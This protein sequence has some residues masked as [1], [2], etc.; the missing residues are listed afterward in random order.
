MQRRNRNNS[1]CLFL[2]K[3]TYQYF[4][5]KVDETWEILVKISNEFKNSNDTSSQAKN[6]YLKY[7][8]KY[9]EMKNNLKGIKERIHEIEKEE[10]NNNQIPNNNQNNENV[11]ANND[12]NEIIINNQP[13]N[14]IIINENDSINEG[15]E[16]ENS[17]KINNSQINGKIYYI[18]NLKL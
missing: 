10:M 5:K 9:V 1:L 2:L 14:N 7:F 4:E 13:N 12:T 17:E 16:K 3:L 6:K 8:F 11:P 18:F 15:G